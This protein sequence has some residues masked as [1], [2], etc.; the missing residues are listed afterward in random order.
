MTKIILSLILL[1]GVFITSEHFMNVENDAK[2]YF[3]GVILILLLLV[4]SIS[5]KGLSRFMTALRSTYIG[6]GVSIVCF[7]LSTY[8]LLQYFGAFSSRH[9][10]FPITGKW[11]G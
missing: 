1:G 4:C 9:Y 10:A 11:Y 8:G 7:I 6:L 3:I 5:R 2:A